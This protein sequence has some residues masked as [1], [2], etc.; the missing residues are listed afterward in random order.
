M[1]LVVVSKAANA[2]VDLERVKRW[3]RVDNKDEDDR[4]EFLLQAATDYVEQEARMVFSATVYELILDA[5]PMVNWYQYYP[6]MAPFPQLLTLGLNFFLPNQTINQP[7]YP[8]TSIDSI[9]YVDIQTGVLTTL[10]ASKYTVDLAAGRVAPTSQQ[11][12]PYT[13]NQLNS[14]TIN[15]HAG[16]AAGAVPTA[17]QMAILNH[18]LLAYM[19]PGG[20]PAEDMDNLNR[21][22]I[23]N[24]KNILV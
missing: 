19:N 11:V 24:R 7:I 20:I 3:L 21:S 5:F 13:K 10:D 12:W 15:F 6:V 17:L 22:I 16:F 14:V 9:Q 23:A 18:C 2:V 8:V 4:I 1:S